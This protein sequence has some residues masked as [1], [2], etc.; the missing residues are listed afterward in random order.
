VDNGRIVDARH[1]WIDVSEQVQPDAHVADLVRSAGK[2]FE[3]ML[4]EVV[5]ETRLALD[6]GLNMES[7]MDNFLLEGLLHVTGAHMAFSNGWR[8]GA[9]VLPGPIRLGDLYNMAPMNPP[10]STVE[11]TGAEMCDMLEENIEH[12]YARDPKNQMGGYLKRALG[13]RV[14]FK[15]ENPKGHRVQKVFVGDAI[16]RPDAVYQAA[17]ITEQGVPARYGRNRKTRNETLIDALRQ[18]LKDRGPVEPRLRG[19]FTAV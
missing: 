11:L 17:F 2:P 9:P 15:I 5:G 6:R 1:Q 3:E 4:S 10:V 19:T 13:I 12:T 14:L 18:Y 16:V 7:T 8:Y